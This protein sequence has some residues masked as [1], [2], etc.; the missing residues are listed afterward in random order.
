MKHLDISK[1][2]LLIKKDGNFCYTDKKNML[3]YSVRKEEILTSYLF[4]LKI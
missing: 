3:N 4:F 2:S 1:M